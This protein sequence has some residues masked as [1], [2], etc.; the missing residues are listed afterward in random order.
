MTTLTAKYTVHS[1]WDLDKLGITINEINDW[2][3]KYDTLSIQRVKDG[4]WEEFDG[5][6]SEEQFKRP[7]SIDVDGKEVV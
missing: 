7:F 5:Q 2:E 1:D 4:E 6:T 3:I